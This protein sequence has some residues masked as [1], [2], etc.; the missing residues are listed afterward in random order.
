MGLASA[1]FGL[2]GSYARTAGRRL[3]RG[4][5]A[6]RWL[7]GGGIDPTRRIPAGESAGAGLSIAALCALRDA[8]EPLPAGAALICPWVDLTL[9]SESV[10]KNAPYD[11][12]DRG[13]ADRWA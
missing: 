9:S 3:R 13:V 1:M 5:A 12:L 11:W 6:L 7:R 10:K 4:P 2:A 8:G